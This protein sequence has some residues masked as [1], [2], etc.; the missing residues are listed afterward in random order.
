MAAALVLTFPSS[1]LQDG[2][3]EFLTTVKGCNLLASEGTSLASDPAF[4]A[5]P[6]PSIT[7]V[8]STLQVSTVSTFPLTMTGL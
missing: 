5:S 6:S 8:S 4:N 3:A 7:T 2:L 1:H